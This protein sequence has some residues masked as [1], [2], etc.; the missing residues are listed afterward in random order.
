MAFINESLV[1]AS[2]AVAQAYTEVFTQELE[3]RAQAVDSKKDEFTQFSDQ[4]HNLA[5][6]IRSGA[7]SRLT[8]SDE[9]TTAI[10]AAC[11]YIKQ[12][13]ASA[14]FEDV[15]KGRLA[16]SLFKKSDLA[17]VNVEVF[18]MIM[19]IR[20]SQLYPHYPALNT[21]EIIGHVLSGTLK[22]PILSKSSNVAPQSL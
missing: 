17:G 9:Q 16:F 3:I 10:S 14:L 7:P 8:L 21:S 12:L 13:P 5:D 2:L 1:C 20:S 4:I 6:T 18:N 22:L 11:C 19:E 15:L